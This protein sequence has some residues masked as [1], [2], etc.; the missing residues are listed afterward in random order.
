MKWWVCCVVGHYW[1]IGRAMCGDRI[2]CGEG[3]MVDER[4]L[5]WGGV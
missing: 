2:T 4:S 3:R 5:G 1:G